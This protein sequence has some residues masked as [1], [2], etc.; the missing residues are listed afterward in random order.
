MNEETTD[1]DRFRREDGSIDLIALFDDNDSVIDALDEVDSEACD[2]V[3]G[4][5][6]DVQES[7]S[8]TSRQAAITILTL[9]T[10]AAYNKALI[11][12]TQSKVEKLD[13]V[14]RHVAALGAVL[15]IR[16]GLDGLSFAEILEIIDKEL[17]Q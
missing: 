2:W 7:A 17:P 15:S 4:T 3:R 14:L 16:A 13:H 10:D 6:A 11:S 12:K 8:F 5:L 1:W 9:L